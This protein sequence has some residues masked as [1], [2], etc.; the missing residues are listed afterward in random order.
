M[1][2]FAL[3][4]LFAGVVG[5]VGEPEGPPGTS[6][7]DLGSCPPSGCSNASCV[8]AADGAR[9]VGFTAQEQRGW[10]G[11]CV[12]E[13]CTEYVPVRCSL[14][15]Q[16]P[17]TVVGCDGSGTVTGGYGVYFKYGDI[18]AQCVGVEGE[19]GYCAPGAAC[20]V[21]NADGA[22]VGAGTCL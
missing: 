6:P 2:R 4:V 20:A 17:M 9:C 19:Y 15:V 1:I 7:A 5:C 16:P 12:A 18:G 13:V 10:G 8:G 14:K 11:Y 21:Y 22:F 3:V